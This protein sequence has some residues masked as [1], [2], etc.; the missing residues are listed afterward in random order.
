M[1]FS[2]NK[3]SK[4]FRIRLKYFELCYLCIF[5]KLLSITLAEFIIKAI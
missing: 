5:L 1:I 3:N 4:S 2:K